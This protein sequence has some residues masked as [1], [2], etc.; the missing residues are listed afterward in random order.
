MHPISLCVIDS[1]IIGN[2]ATP[3][4]GICRMEGLDEIT[5]PA[6]HALLAS[7]S[8]P[9]ASHHFCLNPFVQQIFYWVSTLCQALFLNNDKDGN[10]EGW[11]KGEQLLFPGYIVCAKHSLIW[12]HSVLTM[13][14]SVCSP[15]T[16]VKWV[17]SSSLFHK[18]LSWG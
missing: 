16:P 3:N 11:R 1:C 15:E 5:G 13:D 8:F 10:D 18:W 7:S 14:P 17:Q 6:P 2:H 4:G 12:S 9:L